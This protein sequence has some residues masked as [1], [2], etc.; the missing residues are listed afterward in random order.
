LG[1][2]LWRADGFDEI[3]VTGGQPSEFIGLF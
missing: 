2:L 1:D 3:H